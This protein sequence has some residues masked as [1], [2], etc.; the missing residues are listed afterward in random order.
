MML[1]VS[2]PPPPNAAHTSQSPPLKLKLHLHLLTVLVVMGYLSTRGFYAGLQIQFE[3]FSKLQ[4]QETVIKR[5]FI[6]KNCDLYIGRLCKY[7]C[8][9]K[10]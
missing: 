3:L 4:V 8:S 6:Y 10:L 2:A 5:V 1:C 9:Q 7:S